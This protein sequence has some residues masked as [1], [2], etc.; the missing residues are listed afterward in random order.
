MTIWFFLALSSAI[1]NSLVQAFFNY[2]VSLKRVSKTTAVFWYSLIASIILFAVSYILGI[3]LLKSGFWTAILATSAI[4]AFTGPVLLRAYEL[5]EFSSVYSMVLL[6]P[7]FSLLISAVWL[8]EIPGMY[9]VLGVL[10]TVLGLYIISKNNDGADGNYADFK[11]GNSLGVLVALLWAVTTIFDK[12][13]TL[14]SDPIFAP[15]VGLILIAFTNGAYSLFKPSSHV[16]ENAGGRQS[17]FWTAGMF[18]LIPLGML[19]ALSNVLHNAALAQGFVAYTLAI[20]RTGILLGVFWGWLFF[21]EKH[22][23]RKLFG[24]VVAVSGVAAILLA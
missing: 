12:Q 20:K 21:K 24:A 18:L 15:A 14:R 23:R 2:F 9:G 8:G 5:G 19:F 17:Q 6:T 16:G 1:S 4:N 10:L 22:L 3:P 7:V 11:K 13:A